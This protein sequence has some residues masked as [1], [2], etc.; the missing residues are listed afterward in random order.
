MQGIFTILFTLQQLKKSCSVPFRKL[1]IATTAIDNLRNGT[2]HNFLF[3]KNA[4]YI[5]CM[6]VLCACVCVCMHVCVCACIIKQ[7]GAIG[8]DRQ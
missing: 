3:M 1:S 8:S 2:E 7:Q 6:R 5:Q 4:T